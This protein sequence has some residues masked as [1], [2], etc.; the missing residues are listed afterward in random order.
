MQICGARQI[1]GTGQYSC[2]K[3][4]THNNNTLPN[5]HSQTLHWVLEDDDDRDI[6]GFQDACEPARPK[7]T[8]QARNAMLINDEFAYA[9]PTMTLAIDFVLLSG[10]RIACCITQL[11]LVHEAGLSVQDKHIFETA[12]QDGDGVPV[13][14]LYLP[15]SNESLHPTSDADAQWVSVATRH[16]QG[17]DPLQGLVRGVL[18]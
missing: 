1:G 5:K 17:G 14:V 18:R 4:P 8:L 7:P 15:G 10:Q 2:R 9:F 16:P 6:G 12:L 13:P 11:V 3:M